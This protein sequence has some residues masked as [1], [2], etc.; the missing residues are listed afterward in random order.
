M[1]LCI[2]ATP[3][4]G[5]KWRLH[6]RKPLQGA[7]RWRI[8]S[9][10]EHFLAHLI[11]GLA[12][13]F[14]DA[15]KGAEV[16]ALGQAGNEVMLAAGLTGSF[17]MFG[18]FRRI[19]VLM[20]QGAAVD[21]AHEGDLATVLLDQVRGVVGG[22]DALPDVD[23]HLDHGGH[24]VGG[25]GIAVVHDQL[26]AVILPE[27]IG[28]FVGFQVKLIEHGRRKER[29]DLAAP[30]VMVEQ[31]V[32]LEISDRLLGIFDLIIDEVVDQLV[33]A[34]RFFVQVHHGGFHAHEMVGHLKCSRSKED[35]HELLLAVHGFGVLDGRFPALQAGFDGRC[36]HIVPPFSDI[37]EHDVFGVVDREG[38]DL[39]FRPL[40]GHPPFVDDRMPLLGPFSQRGFHDDFEKFILVDK[41]VGIAALDGFHQVFAFGEHG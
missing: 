16:Q 28:S 19:P 37:L 31:G 15:W 36:L 29:G 17:H 22:H 30:V 14:I 20:I 18:D 12:G 35:A 24:Q 10:S 9:R 8:R 2:E 33:H 27:P 5:A 6:G 13:G 11:D 3:G 34:L 25:I 40:K 23:A 26:H 41:P 4:Q 39:I 21:F 38:T 32:G 7:S 1:P